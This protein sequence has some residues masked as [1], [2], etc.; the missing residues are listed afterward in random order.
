MEEKAKND[1]KEKKKDDHIIN[2]K[3]NNNSKNNSKSNGKNHEKEKDDGKR[4]RNA[5]EPSAKGKKDAKKDDNTRKINRVEI[6]DSEEEASNKPSKKQKT[7]DSSSRKPE[8]NKKNSGLSLSD[9]LKTPEFKEHWGKL[10]EFKKAYATY[11]DL[12]ERCGR[13]DAETKK[14]KK[15]L[16]DLYEYW[17]VIEKIK[18]LITKKFKSSNIQEDFSRQY[19]AAVDV[20]RKAMQLL[21]M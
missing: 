21:E 9:L 3:G 13:N 10:M 14:A 18:T 5:P 19:D 15:G 11:L 20:C 16:V 4:G 12:R 2:E 6:S 1:K 8:T 7:D 17:N